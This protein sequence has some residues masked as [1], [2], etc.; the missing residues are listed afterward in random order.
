MCLD[1]PPLEG[2]CNSLCLDATLNGDRVG[3]DCCEFHP[4]NRACV[5]GYVATSVPFSKCVS[6]ECGVSYGGHWCYGCS[7]SPPG[8]NARLKL[9][10]GMTDN[11]S[12][13]PS[14]FKMEMCAQATER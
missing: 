5:N 10:Q 11:F 6:T 9:Y 3:N 2:D 1:I 13:C 8:A 14:A 4:K 12:H 7:T